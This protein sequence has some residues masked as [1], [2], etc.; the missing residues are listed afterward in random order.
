[1]IL[2]WQFDHAYL[3]KN[4]SGIKKFDNGGVYSSNNTE[5]LTNDELKNNIV[6]LELL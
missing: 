2:N 4:Y 6:N 3:N 1:M 5:R